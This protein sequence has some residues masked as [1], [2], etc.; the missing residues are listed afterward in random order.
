MSFALPASDLLVSGLFHRHG[1]AYTW[2][3]PT[4]CVHNV[5][6]GKLWIEQ[7]GTVEIVNHRCRR[8]CGVLQGALPPGSPQPVRRAG[9]VGLV[10]RWYRLWYLLLLPV[11]V[12]VMNMNLF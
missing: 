9:P 5:L 6:V 4:C 7:Y 3:N 1:E 11:L 10:R 8:A 12:F 2:T